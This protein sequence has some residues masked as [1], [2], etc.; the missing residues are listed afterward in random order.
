VELGGTRVLVTGASGGLGDAI[1]RAWAAHR[2]RVVVTGRREEALRALAA[3]IGAEVVCADLADGDAVAR[4]A[5]A[6]G[7]IDV[8]VSNAAPARGTVDSFSVE[9]ISQST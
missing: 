4:L 6:V 2:A 1:A 7:D 3:E 9:E 5:D 8:L